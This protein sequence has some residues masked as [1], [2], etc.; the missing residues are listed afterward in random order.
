MLFHWCRL[1]SNLPVTQDNDLTLIP[2]DTTQRGILGAGT[3]PVWDPCQ[4]VGEAQLCSCPG[5]LLAFVCKMG[6]GEQLPRW[7]GFEIMYLKHEAAFV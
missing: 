7:L 2:G 4:P 1:P 3:P 5:Q 6:T